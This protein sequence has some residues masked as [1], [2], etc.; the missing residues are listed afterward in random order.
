[1]KKMTLR[2]KLLLGGI[3]AVLIPLLVVGVFSAVRSSQSLEKEALAR[4]ERIADSLAAM[5][6]MVLKEELKLVHE[7]AAMPETVAA[8]SKYSAGSPAEAEV[9]RMNAALA[10]VMKRIGHDYDQFYLVDANGRI[11]ADNV[12]GKLKGL[13]VS[14]RDYF[15]SAKAGKAVVNNVAKSKATGHIVAPIGAPIY[16]ASGQFVGVAAAAVKID[17]LQEQFD[18]VRVGKTGYPFMVDPKGIVIAHPKKEFILDLDLTKQ[19]GMEAI[20]AKMLA[21]QRGSESYVFRGDKKIA[22]F[23]PVPITGW[24]VGFTQN[25][26]EFLGDAHFIRNVILGVSLAFLIVTILAVLVFAGKISNPIARAA[27]DLNES[28]QQLV[29]ACAE[30]SGASQSLAEGSSQQAAAVEETSSSLEELSS[31]TK[32]NADNAEHANALMKE[33]TSVVN[34]AKDSMTK[35]TNSMGEISKASEETSKIIKTIDEIAFQTNL[36][37][38]NAAVEAAR[39]GEAGAGFA[40]VAEE[41]RNLAMRAAEAA[42]NT[43]VLIE[44]TV[45]KIGEGSGLVRTTNEDFMAVADSALKVGELVAEISAASH[46]QSTGIDQIS[47]AVA[48]MDKVVQQ[49]AA[50]AEETASAAEEMNAQAEQVRHVAKTLIDVVGGSDAV[51]G[52]G[53]LREAVTRRKAVPA[54]TPAVKKRPDVKKATPGKLIPLTDKEE[55]EFKDF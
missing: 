18:A 22:G 42:K 41:V 25:V 38:L 33:T 40:V 36:L 24:S 27:H 26:D 37:A 46:E 39:A 55:G 12:G 52:L 19:A 15:K 1:M 2:M 20:V 53:S 13:D 28:A 50:N 35:L 6:Q 11:F 29:S 23:A 14:E 48:E 31:M 45:R 4:S 10:A 51:G 9:E 44:D 49:N 32:Q 54:P 5:V 47:R 16:D 8:A 30:V 43:A 21:K 17:F 7:L 34:R 3:L